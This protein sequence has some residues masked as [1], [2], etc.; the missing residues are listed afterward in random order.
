[1]LKRQNRLTEDS[2]FQKIWKRGRSFY[3]KILG[4]KMLKNDLPFSRFG[5]VVGNKISKKSTV[6][7]RIKRQLRETISNNLTEIVPGNDLVINA[8]PEIV[9]KKKKDI[10]SDITLALKKLGALNS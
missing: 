1:M 8:L 7:N 5:I 6:R 3:T 9:G 2:D 10:E 4:F